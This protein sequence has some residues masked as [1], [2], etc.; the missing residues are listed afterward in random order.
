MI[1][2]KKGHTLGK[3][4]QQLQVSSPDSH[5]QTKSTTIRTILPFFKKKGIK[6]IVKNKYIHI[7]TQIGK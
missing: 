7:Y 1:I 4:G 6:K 3:C 5:F 2:K